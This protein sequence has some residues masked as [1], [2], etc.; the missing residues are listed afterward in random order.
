MKH[1]RWFQYTAIACL[2]FLVVFLLKLFSPQVALGHSRVTPNISNSP[3]PD[4]PIS[5]VDYKPG[6]TLIAASYQDALKEAEKQFICFKSSKEYP[7]SQFRG[8]SQSDI[9]TRI[10]RRLASQL[11]ECVEQNRRSIDFVDLNNLFRVIYTTRLL[12]DSK[13]AVVIVGVGSSAQI[14]E[15]ARFS[16][17]MVDYFAANTDKTNP[18]VTVSN[19]DINSRSF[20]LFKEPFNLGRLGK[21]VIESKG[22]INLPSNKLR[23]S[24]SNET[25][26]NTS[27]DIN[28]ELEL[29][30]RSES[31]NFFKLNFQGKASDFDKNLL[32]GKKKELASAELTF[33]GLLMK[34]IPLYFED[35]KEKLTKDLVI[36]IKT[37]ST[38]NQTTL[39]KKIGVPEY[40][41]LEEIRS[42][43]KQLNDK[44][45]EFR[46]RQEQIKKEPS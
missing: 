30:G 32:S 11:S 12:Q 43:E 45:Y 31:F 44:L 8:F 42:I 14:P 6:K 37:D 33:A 40:Q 9:E 23:L 5:L 13:T 22:N 17:G 28:H 46:T 7:I 36:E 35:R 18:A 24:S 16:E 2:A 29:D 26:I 20:I 27:L 25:S 38:K 19:N 1:H 34:G 15:R 39:S 3:S 41:K 4:L 21:L 10:V